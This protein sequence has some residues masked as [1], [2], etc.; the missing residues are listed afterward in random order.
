MLAG[1]LAFGSISAIAS[2]GP[3][4]S[5]STDDTPTS[6]EGPTSEETTTTESKVVSRFTQVRMEGSIL[7]G[8]SVD[9]AE[10]ITVIYADG[11]Q[12]HDFVVT[13][14]DGYVVNG[15]VVTFTA[16]GD[17]NLEVKAG[18]GEN[19]KSLRYSVKVVTETR[20]AFDTWF[21]SIDTDYAFYN[22]GFDTAG[23]AQL[24]GF[25]YHKNDDYFGLYLGEDLDF[26]FAKLKDGNHYEGVISN[27]KS[28][29]EF[30]LT[31]NPGVVNWS[32]YIFGTG[33]NTVVSSGHFTSSVNEEGNEVISAGV[34]TTTQFVRYTSCLTYGGMEQGM[35]FL[36]FVQGFSENTA[37]LFA[38]DLGENGYDYWVI[39]DVGAAANPVID[40]Y[41]VNG[42][43]P[44]AVDTTMLD[45]TIANIR[46]A[47]N[48]TM[49]ATTTLLDASGAKLN[50]NDLVADETTAA[51]GQFIASTVF[52]QQVTYVTEDSVVI[53]TDGRTPVEGFY[54]DGDKL[55]AFGYND[56][57]PA[58]VEMEGSLWDSAAVATY[59]A[60]TE[61][62]SALSFTGYQDAGEGYH[63]FSSEMGAL[64]VNFEGQ[65]ITG[66]ASDNTAFA[67]ALLNTV[68]TNVAG[69]NFY[70]Q[71]ASLGQIY[72]EDPMYYANDERTQLQ[73]ISG[74][75]SI[76]YIVNPEANL[77]QYSIRIPMNDLLYAIGGLD[78]SPVKYVTYNWTFMYAGQTS[79]PDISAFKA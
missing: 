18:S 27:V 43:I 58:K 42:D 52:M 25:G 67:K 16:F 59:L 41:I 37:G 38:I 65:S 61:S 50:I 26:I 64:I 53:T 23:N 17:Y 49:M 54:Q 32:N 34:D 47:K 69:G 20:K 79:A 40:D 57:T 70:Q 71:A 66:T 55:Y 76:D 9:L 60:P 35:Q 48:Y 44:A 19:V 24:G 22:I 31:F 39:T 15:S 56:T 77:I 14:G 51:V 72:C 1:V 12:D 74:L 11:S 33:L 36:G 73:S 29:E 63:A 4:S 62:V 30:D 6:V 3:T 28:T 78:I 21:D 46:G 7:V 13:E 2:C 10:K 75:L 68:D 8:E 5:P 45:S